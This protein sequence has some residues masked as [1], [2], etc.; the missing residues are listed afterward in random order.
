[1]YIDV[2]RRF[3]SGKATT[4]ELEDATLEQLTELRATPNVT[5]EQRALSRVELMLEEA[6]EG[7][8]EIIEVYIAA[9]MVLDTMES[10]EH[11]LVLSEP[12]YRRI[13]NTDSVAFPAVAGTTNTEPSQISLP[14]EVVA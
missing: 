7:T 11:S 10:A 13:I 6:R 5:V 14:A 1:M 8:R 3:V 12:D 9:S 4:Q 2:F